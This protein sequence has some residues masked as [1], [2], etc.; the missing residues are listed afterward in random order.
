MNEEYFKLAVQITSATLDG[1]FLASTSIP[2]DG[3]IVRR[4]EL[5]YD[6]IAEAH[7]RIK[8]SNPAN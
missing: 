6:T 8:K 1:R 4:I 7:A 2:V 5:A 3:D